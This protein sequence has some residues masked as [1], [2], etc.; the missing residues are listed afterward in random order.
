MAEDIENGYGGFESD[1]V[2]V[3][4][5]N[6]GL[7]AGKTFLK[8]FEWTPTGGKDNTEQEAL[9]IVFEINATEKSYRVFPVTKAFIKGGGE[10][11]DRNSAEFKEELANFKAKIFH[12][13]HCFVSRET[14]EV[15]VAKKIE[16]F[17]DYCTIVAALLPKDFSTR[18]LDIFMQF[19]YNI[20]DN[21]SRT[22]L[23]I[24]TKQ[25][26]GKWLVPAQAGTWNKKV[27]EGADDS[28]KE[29]LTYVNEKGEKH[30][31]VRTGWFMNNNFAKQQSDSTAVNDTNTGGDATGTANSDSQ[32]NAAPVTAETW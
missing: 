31:F 11:T 32:Q 30:P 26:H 19:Q 5:F 16:S 17:K 9:D 18:P 3:S 2:K 8:K 12:I 6:F 13:L 29:A 23:E 22:Y 28:E 4:P 20:P 10:T 14:F 1:E 24:P 15:A 21:K 7:N 25:K 27:I